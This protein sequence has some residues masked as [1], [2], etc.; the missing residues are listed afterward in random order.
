MGGQNENQG[1]N[2]YIVQVMGGQNEN[3]GIKVYIENKT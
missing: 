2:V 3:Q 1:I